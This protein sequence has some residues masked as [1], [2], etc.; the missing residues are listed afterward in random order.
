MFGLLPGFA[1]LAGLGICGSLGA[2]VPLLLDCASAGLP[3]LLFGL[4]GCL[5]GCLAWAAC[6]LVVSLLCLSFAIVNI[7][8]RPSAPWHTRSV[9]GWRRRPWATWLIPPTKRLGAWCD[10]CE[11]CAGRQAGKA[12]ERIAM[13]ILHIFTS[14]AYRYLSPGL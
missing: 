3:G 14:Q 9:L 6:F 10:A 11:S 1:R 12:G 2:G 13:T 8:L 7:S 4:A 5:A